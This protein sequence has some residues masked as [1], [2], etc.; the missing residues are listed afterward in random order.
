MIRLSE[1]SLADLMAIK[2]ELKRLYDKNG[3]IEYRDKLE[4]CKIEVNNRLSLIK[5]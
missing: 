2:K 5:Y 1:L 3:L 4:A